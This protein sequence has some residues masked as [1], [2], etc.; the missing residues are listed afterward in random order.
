MWTISLNSPN[1]VQHGDNKT[2]IEALAKTSWLINWWVIKWWRLLAVR[3]IW[4][5]KPWAFVVLSAREQN[6]LPCSSM[7]NHLDMDAPIENVEVSLMFTRYFS[8]FKTQRFLVQ[9]IH[10][11]RMFKFSLWTFSVLLMSIKQSSSGRSV[12]F[13]QR[14]RSDWRLTNENLF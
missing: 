8:T 11:F 13:I 6:L 14:P 1:D 9:S 4:Q 5:R 12:C 10:L 7:E 3:D 2:L